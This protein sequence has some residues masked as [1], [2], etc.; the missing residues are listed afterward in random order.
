MRNE[1]LKKQKLVDLLVEFKMR[2]QSNNRMGL[3][4][5]NILSQEFLTNL[6]NVVYH[7]ENANFKCLDKIQTNYPAVDIADFDLKI[8]YQVTSENDTSK[9]YQTIGVFLSHIDASKKIE[10]LRFIILNDINW[11][12][13]QF[14][15][16]ENRFKENSLPYDKLSISSI[17][18][19]EKEIG[20]ATSKQQD[21]II[22]LLEAELKTL[23]KKNPKKESN[24]ESDKLR[25]ELYSRFQHFYLS[26]WSI[27]ESKEEMELKKLLKGK[28]PVS[29]DLLA[30][31]K[32]E[33]ILTLWEPL[34]KY[35]LFNINHIYWSDK[36]YFRRF[37][38]SAKMDISI[39][40][41]YLALDNFDKD[42]MRQGVKILKEII[43]AP[44]YSTNGASAINLPE[45]DAKHE[46]TE[47]LK[48]F[49]NL[50][51]VFRGLKQ[52]WG[53]EAT[54]DLLELGEDEIENLVEAIEHKKGILMFMNA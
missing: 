16:I 17:V 47:T 10:K 26:P 37:V 25:K 49:D 42:K 52:H 14:D 3:F 13:K 11:T 27:S 2:I 29:C 28:D 45:D 12:E 15:N 43:I 36:P 21:K 4:D 54:K 8:A 5:V 40:Y 41:I 20:K 51:H 19:L 1:L 7:G 9:I 44:T 35:Q 18:E 33:D 31:Q 48:Y 6:L 50:I 32:Y 53:Y 22:E 23:E 38:Q 24:D 30:N 34:F 39:A 46:N